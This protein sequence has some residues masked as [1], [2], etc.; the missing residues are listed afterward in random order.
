MKTLTELDA[1]CKA[2]TE[3]PWV[4]EDDNEDDIDG[5]LISWEGERSD[6]KFITTARTAL[7]ELVARL[8]RLKLSFE[9]VDK[10]VGGLL[11]LYGRVANALEGL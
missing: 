10:D 8:E 3:G 11:W 4:D 6:A 7:P 1:I 2:A 9:Q 5:F